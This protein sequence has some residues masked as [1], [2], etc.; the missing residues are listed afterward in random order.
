[1]SLRFVTNGTGSPVYDVV[2]SRPDHM[3]G[4]P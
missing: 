2:L 4:L 1:L 3:S